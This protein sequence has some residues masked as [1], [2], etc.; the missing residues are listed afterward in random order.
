MPPD[1]DA[2]LDAIAAELYAVRPDEFTAARN[3]RAAVSDPALAKRVKTLRKPTVAAWTVDLL[4][5]TGGLDEAIELAAAL[6]EAQGDLDAAELSRL[7]R[8]RR[9]LVG[10]L[11]GQAV[12]RAEAAGVTVSAGARDDIA[13]TINAAVMDAAAAAAVM[14]GRLVTSLEAG[15]I[16]PARLGDAVG[17]S[18]PGVVEA[19]PRD[20]L[21]AR[22]ER[23]A[24][25]RAARDADRL[26]GEAQRELAKV[27]ARRVRA[28]ERLQHLEERI[29]EL[30][31]DL[32]R[33][34]DEASAARA[35]LD[36]AERER[37][38]AAT[39]ARAAA[40]A[41]ARAHRAIDP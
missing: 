22:R 40:D 8:Q 35:A 15:A 38:D 25:E 14:T 27:D 23:K 5:R 41:A 9:A 31:R 39:R 29:E 17:G 20:D 19:P 36:D 1:E 11:A 2:A 37:V 3:A 34:E 30:H 32:T 6:R 28:E 26:A 21:A 16:D 12:E 4:V 18:V 13:K 33:L 24:A 7:G 10:A